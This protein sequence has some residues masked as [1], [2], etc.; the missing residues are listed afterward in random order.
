MLSNQDA[1]AVD[2]GGQLTQDAVVAQIAAKVAELCGHDEG[3]P[4]E[5]LSSFG[6][7]SISVAELGAFIR[8]QFNHQV[9]ALELMTTATCLSLAEAIM[10]GDQSG[11]ED[12]AG[13]EATGA[14]HA[15]AEPPPARRIPSVFSSAPADHFPNGA[16]ATAAAS[17]AAAAG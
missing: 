4:E 8:M 6:L 10:Q 11:D 5:P 1:F 12:D 16:R 9:S 7:T 2:T 13:A 14:E 3:S 17:A 15:I